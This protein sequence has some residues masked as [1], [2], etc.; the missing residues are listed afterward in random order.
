MIFWNLFFGILFIWWLF[1]LRKASRGIPSRSIPQ[2]TP[3]SERIVKCISCGTNNRLVPAPENARYI[4][5]SCRKQLIEDPSIRGSTPDSAADP[6]RWS[7]SQETTIPHE[8]TR[9]PPR[10]K[11]PSSDGNTAYR[12]VD[13]RK[14]SEVGFQDISESTGSVDNIDGLVDAFT[15]Q[16]LDPALGLHECKGCHVF[17][18]HASVQVLAAEN[19]GKCVSCRGGDI[20]PVST[21][22][23]KVVASRPRFTPSVITLANFRSYAGSVVT[24][25]GRVLKIQPSRNGQNFGVMFE[26]KSWRDGLKLLVFR[27]KINAVGGE[28]FIRGLRGR[29]IRVRGL[30]QKHPMFGYQIIVTERGMIQL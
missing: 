3:K 6:N 20:V 24:F 8:V 29:N 19:A 21:A 30:L 11:H 18:H 16:Q 7:R 15:G 26:D 13:R 27:S 4:C 5:K 2:A 10:T 14:R 28:A 25:E 23:R 9:L 17:Y 1:F 12:P 22:S